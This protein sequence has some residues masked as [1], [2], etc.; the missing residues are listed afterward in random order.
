MAVGIV[1]PALYDLVQ[2]KNKGFK[3]YFSDIY[4]YSDLIFVYSG[5]VNMVLQ[6]IYSDDFHPSS[7]VCKIL[8]ILTI[9]CSIVK[10]F[11]F[12]RVFGGLSYLVTMLFQVMND[13]KVFLLFYFILLFC[14][15]L[16]YCVIGVAN[17]NV[18]GP[19][20]DWFDQEGY[21]SKTWPN[22][23][24]IA[25]KH[26]W[27]YEGNQNYEDNKLDLTYAEYL[28]VDLFIANILNTFRLSLGDFDFQQNAYLTTAEGVV[29]WIIFVLVL[30]ISNI[31]FLNFIIAEASASYEKVMERLDGQILLERASMITECE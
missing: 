22:G 10:T 7:I 21:L 2:L 27:Y 30:L 4:N 24:V 3:V 31:I 16:Y 15:S 19:Y 13:L 20:R 1:Y 5:I 12:L 6:N 8:M 17:P 14:F 11:L 28:P 9:S 18:E 25:D 23:T 29:V 26:D